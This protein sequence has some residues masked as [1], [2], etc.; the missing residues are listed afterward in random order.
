MAYEKNE[1]RLS[2]EIF[3]YLLMH[4]ELSEEAD[5]RLYMAY[6]ESPEV[7]NLVKS[8]GEAAH[9]SVEQYGS[10]IYLIPDTDNT[11]LGYSR[12]QLKDLLVSSKGTNR[13][14]YLAQFAILVLLMEF[15]DGQGVSSRTRDYLRTADLQNHMADYLREGAERMDEESQ[16]LAGIAFS[17]MLQAY[18]A[19]RSVEGSRQKTTKEGFLNGILHFLDEQGLIEYVQED[20]IIRTT[21]KLDSF[22]DWNLLNQNHYSRLKRI[23]GGEV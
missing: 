18:E 6:A 19:L 8:Q 4:H 7:Q 16:D 17:D 12:A 20:E 3:Y 21:R 14:Y 5:A 15:Y 13:D 23:I 11:F 9:S 2:Q 1:I 10:T 22:M